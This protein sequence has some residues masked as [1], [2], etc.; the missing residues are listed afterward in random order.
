MIRLL[1]IFFSSKK[2]AARL[3]K[4]LRKAVL[5]KNQRKIASSFRKSF[6][7]LLEEKNAKLLSALILSYGSK[8]EDFPS[9]ERQISAA[10]LKQAIRILTEN[11][12]DTAAL[13][14]CEYARYDTEAIEILA[15]RGQ[16]DDLAVYLRKDNFVDKEL[17][18]VAVISWEKHNGDIRKNPTMCNVL[19]NIDKF[20]S[21]SIPDNPRVRVIIGQYKEAA[22]LYIKERDLSNAARCYEKIEIYEEACKIY[23]E[24]GDNERASRAAASSGDLEKALQLVVNPERKIK[25]LIQTERFLEA[26]EFAAGLESPDKYFDLIKEQAKQRMAVKKKSHD[27]IGAM[28]LADIAECEFVEREEILLLGR[29]YFDRKI[30]SAASEKDIKLIYK[31]RVKFE[32]K[33]GYFEEAGKLAEEVLEDL[34]LASLL[35]EK[36]NLYNRAIDTASGHSERLAALH[37]KGGNLL[38]AAKLYESAEQYEKAFTLYENIQSFNKA[39]ECFLK[40]DNPKQDIL[41]R[42]YTRAGEFEKVISI[43]MESGDFQDLEKALSIAEAHK[44]SSHVRAIWER[45]SV[46]VLGSE[47]DLEECFIN[48]RNEVFES[49]SQTMGIDFGTTNSVVAIFNKKTQKAEIIRTPRGSIYTPTFFGVDENNHPIFGED[50]QLRSLTAPDCVVARVKRSLGEQKSYSVGGKKYRS[51]EVIA[52]FLQHIKS[53]ADIYVQSKIEARFH[54]LSRQ[55]NLKF[56]PKVLTDF[57][58]KKKRKKHIK[59]A[60]LSVPAYFNDNQKRATR[61]SA[62]IAGL[63]VRRLLHEPSAAAL[64]Y[65][66]QK[67]YSG[68]LAVIDLG[69]GTLDISIVDIGDGVNDVRSIGG[70]TKLGGS[71]IDAVLVQ[72]IRK[73]IRQLFGRDINEETHPTEIARLRD[74]CENLKINLSSVTQATMEL[75]HFL[76]KPKYTFTLTRVELERLS[77]PILARIESTIE[78]TIK[79]YGSSIDN[80]ILVGNATRMPAVRDLVKR[81]IPAKELTGIDPGTVVVRGTALQGAILAGDLTQIVLLDVVPYSL[82]ISAIEM[83]GAKETISRLLEKNSTIPIRK[84]NIY[85]T[86]EDNQSNVHIKI[87]QGESSQPHKNYF[88]GNFTLEGI[89]PAPAHTPQIDVTFDIGTDCVLIVTALDKA[90]DNKQSI[91]IDGAVVLSPKEK[92]NLSSYFAQREKA[93]SFEKKLKQIEQEIDALKL[94]CD[95]TIRVTEHA[96]KDFFEQFYE[97]V[98]VNPQLYQANPGQIREIQDMF[99]QKDQFIHGI[100]KYHDQFASIMSNLKQI[101]TRHLDFSDSDIASKLK[102]RIDTLTHYKQALENTLKSVEKNV[103]RIVRSWNQILESMEP[104][105]EKMNSLDVASYHLTAGRANKAREILESLIPSTEGL[106]EEAFHLLL[107]SYVLLGS[108]EEHRVTHKRF[109]NL[110]NITYP[111]FSHLN[112]YLKTVA[113]SVFMIQGVSEQQAI[114][115]GSGFCIAPNLVITNRHVVEKMSQK[116]IKIIGKNRTYNVEQLELDPINDL[117]ILKVSENLKPCKLGEFSFVEPGEQVLALGFPSPSSNK[118]SENIFISKGI[119]NSIRKID[120]SSE[121]VIFIDTKIG[122]GMSGGPLINELGEVIGI[123]T[124]IKYSMSQNEKGI[125]YMENQPVALPINLVRKYVKSTK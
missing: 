69:G 15:K 16:A 111:D 12:L 66:Y 97:K 78:K 35:Y 77:K 74:A 52:N 46:F 41:I 93:Y 24:I 53:N 48:A 50:A 98:E 36:A 75:H 106:T 3:E 116:Q 28:E 25:L 37:E 113:D 103:S 29:Q 2:I 85:T 105:L 33:A 102:D 124:L 43:Y 13:K 65:A 32:E 6:I 119:V 91:R 83:T 54:D 55:S 117:A 45:M 100:P 49:Y 115:F 39:I 114:S 5:V 4:D 109:G 51:E 1:R 26:R 76:N 70:D 63:R 58:N 94:S 60:V 90:T 14:I 80:F 27:F 72:R 71:D 20:T 108:K 59:D 88:L 104:D 68:K 42:L 101:E 112:S 57:L 17:L 34:S 18:G 61:D 95:E 107:K 92:E 47:G 84:S 120:A 64:A 73:N 81:I 118:H 7:F 82:G 8:I 44:L 67:K 38:K 86:R 10:Q 110:F 31:D 40:T 121:R 56:P 123:L 23:E 122:R 22:I 11:K 99:I 89:P 87:Y 21:V 62:E 19:I 125:F 96:I 9:F 30:T 79:E